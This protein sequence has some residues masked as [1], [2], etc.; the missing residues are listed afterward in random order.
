MELIVNYFELLLFDTFSEII[1][2]LIAIL[3]IA[4]CYGLYKLS[5]PISFFENWF[6]KF[7]SCLLLCIVFSLLAEI[8]LTSII[9]LVAT[10]GHEWFINL[11]PYLSAI[12]G[13]LAF[14]IMLSLATDFKPKSIF[15]SIALIYIMV[16]IL[17][18]TIVMSSPEAARSQAIIT[19]SIRLI[20][21]I[22]IPIYA[23]RKK[24]DFLEEFNL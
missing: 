11:I 13:P 16:N 7:L 14:V 8:A 15:T 5:E 4:A 24:D 22:L 6:L 10:W 2:L 18:W 1:N 23:F 21:S 17:L 3:L 9:F 19:F 20:L 12:L